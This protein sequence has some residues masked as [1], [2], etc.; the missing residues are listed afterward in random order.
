[1]TKCTACAAQQWAAVNIASIDLFQIN[2][3]YDKMCGMCGAVQV[4]I[5]IG[6][7]TCCQCSQHRPRPS[8]RSVP[9]VS[10]VSVPAWARA[11][12]S[13]TPHLQC[14]V[15]GGH[16]WSA[17]T[18]TQCGDTHTD[19]GHGDM[20]GIHTG[21]YCSV[22]FEII[23]KS[24]S[25]KQ[26]KVKMYIKDLQEDDFEIALKVRKILFLLKA[27]SHDWAIRCWKA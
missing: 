23:L 20:A 11:Q 24:T 17:D 25:N 18:D 8:T 1:M 6:G 19:Q 3:K 14:S 22:Q 9:V 5:N 16:S 4:C 12:H 10:V 26:I 7:M 15:G 27:C 21:T 13:S 2:D